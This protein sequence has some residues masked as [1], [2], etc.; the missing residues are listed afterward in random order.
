MKLIKHI[1]DDNIKVK[2]VLNLYTSLLLQHSVLHIT[3]LLFCFDAFEIYGEV[4]LIKPIR[5]SEV[6]LIKNIQDA[7]QKFEHN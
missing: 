3:C 5:K 1:Q 6:K 4:K 7:H 2:K